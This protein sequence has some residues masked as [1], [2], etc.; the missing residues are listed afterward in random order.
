MPDRRRNHGDQ[1]GDRPISRF[2]EQ[3]R[4]A[5]VEFPAYVVFFSFFVLHV[6]PTSTGICN[7]DGGK[8]LIKGTPNKS[9]LVRQIQKNTSSERLREEQCKAHPWK[10]TILLNGL[11]V[12]GQR[13]YHVPRYRSCHGVVKWPE[14][15][16]LWRIFFPLIYFISS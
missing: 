8:N 5:E 16:T 3:V 11:E 14:K 13:L 1:A 7:T 4:T 15:S 6:M 2:W 10:T 9:Y 12:L